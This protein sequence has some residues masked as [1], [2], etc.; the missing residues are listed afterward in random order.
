L[1]SEACAAHSEA[2]L[3]AAFRAWSRP[4]SRRCWWPSWP[5]WS[6]HG[7]LR[8]GSRGRLPGQLHRFARRRSRPI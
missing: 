4:P 2:T 8:V 6:P 5:R 3:T 1:L 7:R